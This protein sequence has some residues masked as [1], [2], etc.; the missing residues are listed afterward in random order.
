MKTKRRKKPFK[1]RPID[2]DEAHEWIQ[3]K[4]AKRLQR[5]EQKRAARDLPINYEWPEEEEDER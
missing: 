2:S 4:R 5:I 3:R 1:S